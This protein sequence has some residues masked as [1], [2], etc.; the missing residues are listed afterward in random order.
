MVSDPGGSASADVGEADETDGGYAFAAG[1]DQILVYQGDESN[2]T[3][4]FGLNTN[5]TEW[6]SS[7]GRS[8]NQSD[9]PPRFERGRDGAEHRG[10]R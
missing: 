2:P 4:I 5:G 8:A 6:G 10:R 3:F 7:A 9:V 1:G